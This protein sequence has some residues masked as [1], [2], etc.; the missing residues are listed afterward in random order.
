MS[1]KFSQT[2]FWVYHVSPPSPEKPT[3]PSDRFRR[4][5]RVDA[6]P[7]CGLLQLRGDFLSQGATGLRQLQVRCGL[8]WP[9]MLGFTVLPWQVGSKWEPRCG[10]HQAKTAFIVW[11]VHGV[12]SSFSILFSSKTRFIH[13]ITSNYSLVISVSL[14]VSPHPKNMEINCDSKSHQITI[15]WITHTHAHIYIC[16]YMCV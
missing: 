2:F 11:S 5:L 16:I 8:P 14:E 15:K 9:H 13:L 1:P 7:G 6:G 4:A 12:T 3:A 10:F